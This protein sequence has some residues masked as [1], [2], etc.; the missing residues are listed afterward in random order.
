LLAAYKFGVGLLLCG[1]AIE[2]VNLIGRDVADVLR[3]WALQ[4]HVDPHHPVFVALAGRATSATPVLL[5][6]YAAVAGGLGG[7]HVIE[8]A[9]LWRGKR[10]AEYLC[11]LSTILL[12]PIEV[13][14]LYE[15]PSVLKAVTLTTNLAVVWYLIRRVR[16]PSGPPLQ[17][18]A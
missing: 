16:R 5:E 1:L 12:V 9:A 11:V 8:G 10:W 7:L 6:E 2:L 3:H 18:T 4:L 14:E 17:C 13:H 15:G